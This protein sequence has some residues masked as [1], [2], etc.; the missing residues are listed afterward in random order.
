MGRPS[1]RVSAPIVAIADVRRRIISR[2][3][4]PIVLGLAV[5]WNYYHTLRTV[6]TVHT[7]ERTSVFPNRLIVHESADHNMKILATEHG[8]S[9]ERIRGF[10]LEFASQNWDEFRAYV[11]TQRRREQVRE[12]VESEIPYP[13]DDLE[14][15]RSDGSFYAVLPDEKLWK[16]EDADGWEIVDESRV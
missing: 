13:I 8:M 3:D 2:V 5:L 7:M 11:E 10:A 12:F 14:I 1:L 6:N 16:I 15:R 9:R 4:I